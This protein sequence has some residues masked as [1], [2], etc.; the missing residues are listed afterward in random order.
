MALTM[1]QTISLSAPPM[2]HGVIIQTTPE[3]NRD[4]FE[5]ALYGAAGAPS[6]DFAAGDYP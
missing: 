6:I 4:R 5:R 1:M 3:Q 2:T